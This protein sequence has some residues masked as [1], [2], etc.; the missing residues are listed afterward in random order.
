MDIVR[1]TADIR[2][3]LLEIWKQVDAKQISASEA[4]L[5]I[6]LARA[7]LE[8][9][10]IEIAYAHLTQTQVPPMPIGGRLPA[11]SSRHEQ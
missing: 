7:V 5:H 8:T 4:R 6:S 10:K 2:A 1:N 3:K 11:P 9:M